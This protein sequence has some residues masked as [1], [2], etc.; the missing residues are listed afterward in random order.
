MI[1]RDFFKRATR[2]VRSSR[3]GKLPLARSAALGGSRLAIEPLEPRMLLSADSV[4][5][6]NEIMYHP[7]GSQDLEWIELHNQMAVDI[8]LSG[9][10]LD[11]AVD[12]EFSEG[13]VLSGGGYLVVAASPVL[14]Q[15]ETGFADALGPFFKRLDN[16]GEEIVLRNN[17][18]RLM[19][20]IRYDDEDPWPVGPD[21]F[22]ASLAKIDPD[23]ASG[24]A[25]NWATSHQVGGTPG[26]INFRDEV[27]TPFIPMD[28]VT[29]VEIGVD[30]KYDASGT[31]LG[32]AWRE[33][34]FD[35]D[36]WDSIAAASPSM[37]ITE[38]STLS[39]DS[40]E[41]QN[42]SG[43]AVDTTGWFV[44]AN[45]AHS[46]DSWHEDICQPSPAHSRTTGMRRGASRGV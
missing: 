32:T 41:I 13:T 1:L 14:L 44:V 42:V 30:W 12:F 17:N 4:V 37:L 20:E 2:P 15:A 45:D 23:A 40:V 5:V 28:T 24:Q 6:F 25:E 18:D 33:P 46:V 7:A 16:G 9:W 31:D 26:A 35:D 43:A 38:I 39:T 22:G 27:F 34:Q 10:R 8:D 29:A 36:T 11:G 3:R 19:D 21:G